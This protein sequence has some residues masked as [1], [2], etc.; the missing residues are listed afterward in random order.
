[1]A[2]YC[3][4]DQVSEN[5]KNWKNGRELVHYVLMN[6]GFESSISLVIFNSHLKN[7]I[8]LFAS[9]GY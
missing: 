8:H 4:H 1:M 5:E 6:Q 7:Y 9:R 3:S 2:D